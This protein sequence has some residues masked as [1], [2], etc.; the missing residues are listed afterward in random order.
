MDKSR[1]L[2]D[3]ELQCRFGKRTGDGSGYKLGLCRTCERYVSRRFA[4]VLWD[5][6]HRLHGQL[7]A[8][9]KRRARR[10]RLSAPAKGV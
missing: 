9:L 10:G 5:S 4:A 7:R 2:L 6:A 1:R 3:K 8:V